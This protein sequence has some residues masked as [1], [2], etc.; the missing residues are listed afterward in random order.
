MSKKVQMMEELE[1]DNVEY[2]K[3]IMEEASAKLGRIKVGLIIAGA[4]TVCSCIMLYA[5]DSNMTLLKGSM[6]LIALFGAIISY[7][8]GGGFGT[9]IKFAM[10]V[11]KFGWFI[12]PFPIDIITGIITTVIALWAF[13]FV[14]VFFVFLNYWQTK[15]NYTEAERYYSCYK[16]KQ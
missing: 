12:T 4:A 3:K 5:S 11:G 14:P 15:K 8:V 13:L 16:E 10:K 9:A 1:F 7:I 2:A 6:M